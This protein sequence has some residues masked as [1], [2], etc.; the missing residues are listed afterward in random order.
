[1]EIALLSL[2]FHPWIVGGLGTYSTEFSWR[3]V[4]LGHG[5]SVYTFNPGDLEERGY[6]RGVRVYRPRVFDFTPA[7]KPIVCQ[8]LRGWGPGF[9]YFSDVLTYNM[10]SVKEIL[11]RGCADIYS[12]HDWLSSFAGI[13]LSRLRRE[14]VVFHVHSTEKGR[15][16]GDGSSLISSLELEMGRK[17]SAVITVSTAMREHLASEGFQPEKIHV[18]HNGVDPEVFDPSRVSESERME[19]RE[20][21]GV[22]EDDWMILYLGRLVWVK[23]VENLIQAFRIVSREIPNTKLVIVGLGELEG[24]VREASTQPDMEGKLSY[25]FEFL[26]VEEKVRY[27][28]AC[29]LAV[30]PSLYEPFGIVALEAMAMQKPVVVGARG[31]SGFRDTVVPSGPGQC[32]V[33]VN[34]YDPADIAWGIKAVLE[35]PERARAMGLNG[36]ERVLERFTWNQCVERTVEVYSELLRA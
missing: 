21:H 6:W 33:H 8:E 11:Y 4:K 3:A 16:L 2:E 1:M 26:P 17:A 12:V 5:V 18:V 29:D 19:I 10:F 9:R 27:Y 23:G 36:R 30:F 15:T 25:R 13:T 22:G 28:A 31:V 14:P 24:R 35:D 7:L 32:G 34:G 20:R